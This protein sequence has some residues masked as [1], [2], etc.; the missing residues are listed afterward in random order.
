M[1]STTSSPV[2]KAYISPDPTVAF[3]ILALGVVAYFFKQQTDLKKRQGGART[4]PGPKGV[5]LIGNLK[6]LPAQKPWVK[7]KEWAD[8][9][10]ESLCVRSKRKICLVRGC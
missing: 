5:P 10:G 8:E 7:L 2:A 3:I 1:P 9:Y 4:L 6:Q